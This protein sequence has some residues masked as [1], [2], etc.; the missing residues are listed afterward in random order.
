MSSGRVIL[1]SFKAGFMWCSMSPCGK[2]LFGPYMWSD[3]TKYLGISV[4]L[5]IILSRGYC[6]KFD[7]TG[8]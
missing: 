8:Q 1:C 7:V 2:G 4:Q 3:L 6:L 5:H